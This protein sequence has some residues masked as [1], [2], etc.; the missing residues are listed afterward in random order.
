MTDHNNVLKT[1]RSHFSGNIF[2]VVVV[3]FLT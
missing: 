3:G 2:I 1:M